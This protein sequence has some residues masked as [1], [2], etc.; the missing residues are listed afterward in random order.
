MHST[1]EPI[2]IV[3]AAGKGTRMQSTVPKALHCFRGKPLVFY[4]IQAALQAGS[5]QIIVVV[6]YGAAQVQARIEKEFGTSIRFVEQSEQRGTGHAVLCVLQALPELQGPVWILN[7]DVPLLRPQTLQQL[8]TAY[9]ASACKAALATT[10]LDHPDGYGRMIRDTNGRIRQI[11]EHQ[12]ANAEERKIRECNAG[13]YC[14]QADI[15]RTELPRLGAENAQKE[16]Y[17]TDLVE[18][19]DRSGEINS[20]QVDPHEVANVN[21]QEQLKTLE[22]ENCSN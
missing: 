2:T 18:K 12:D 21:T 3:L 17:L 7:G 15:L 20:I 13:I 11:R 8:L 22:N 5:K 6:G 9:L 16:I 19:I 4:P 1:S 14:I 10:I